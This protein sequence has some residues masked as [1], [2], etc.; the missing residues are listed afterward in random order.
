LLGVI[1]AGRERALVENY[2]A[3]LGVKAPGIDTSVET[4]SGGNQQKV[5]LG[6]WLNASP[7]IF[8]LDEPTRGI[9]IGA[10]V[11][12]YKLLDRLAGEGVAIIMVSSELP[13][14]L[15]MSDRILVMR[16]GAIVAEFTR[17]EATRE[18]IMECA[19]GARRTGE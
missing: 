15:G 2:V 1:D 19:T 11:E 9:D 5:I 14:I 12:I 13:E 8:I 7:T 3:Q 10:K 16:E 4:L 18:A 6:K 17:E